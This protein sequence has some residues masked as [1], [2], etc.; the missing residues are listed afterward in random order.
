M[1]L[2][3][4][5]ERMPWKA[6]EQLACH[7]ATFHSA[8]Q[9]LPHSL[10]S[11]PTLVPA[12]QPNARATFDKCASRWTPV[13]NTSLCFRAQIVFLHHQLP[14]DRFHT[15]WL[16]QNAAGTIEKYCA[17]CFRAPLTSPT[18]C[19][20]APER[21]C[22]FNPL[23]FNLIIIYT[24]VPFVALLPQLQAVPEFVYNGRHGQL[25]AC[26]LSTCKA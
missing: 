8:V 21:P 17:Q 14:A 19:I 10:S 23:S 1:Q 24:P 25:Y 4:A 11:R 5:L 20:S 2:N 18:H 16:C 9:S 22:T 7:L 15:L 26:S 12:E 13:P 3:G 6:T